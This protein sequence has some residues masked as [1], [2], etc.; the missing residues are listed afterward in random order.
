MRPDL[1]SLHSGT[2]TLDH[3]VC[4]GQAGLRHWSDMLADVERARACIRAQA[5]RLWALYEPDTYRFAVL[6]LALLAEDR[7]VLLPG[8][9]HAGVLAALNARGAQ[10]AGAFEQAALVFEEG[11]APSEFAPWCIAGS[12]AVFTSGSTGS[13]KCI[14]KSLVQVDAELGALE[15]LWGA[16]LGDSA[17]LS[18]VSHQHFYGLL[19]ALLWPLCTGRLFAQKAFV[20]P[21]HLATFSAAQRDLS[22][23]A[24][25][26]S[27]A[28][29]HRLSATMPWDARTK[30]TAV[31]SSGG[32]LRFAAAS[33]VAQALG[34]WPLEVFGSSETGGIAW[35]EQTCADAPWQPFA[36]V[37]VALTESGELT[38]A[39][40]YLPDDE[41]FITADSAT[42]QEDGRFLLGGRL[43][44][45][46]KLEGKRVAL[47]E[48]EQVLRNMDGIDDATTLALPGKRDQ[49][50][51]VLQLS[52]DGWH[53]YRE[54]GHHG[55]CQ[56]LRRELAKR[57]PAVAVPRRWRAV[58]ALP[59]NAQGK[60]VT[61]KV[62]ALFV[63]KSY[64]T[65]LGRRR[66]GE[67]LFL[68]FAALTGENPYF[69]GHFPGQSVLPGVT[70]LAWAQHFAAQ[71]LGIKH[72]YRHMRSVKFR[73][74]VFPE[75]ALE[76][77]LRYE[78]SRET[79]FF[80]YR[81]CD[82]QHSEGRLVG[83]GSE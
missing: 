4:I 41:R 39:S 80:S 71:E 51:A 17:M 6:L 3:P 78:P 9:N 19:F 25:V 36:P 69:E 64:P 28:H 60:L 18:T 27:P 58:T 35:R 63:K 70:Q 40:T 68:E 44:R 30:V 22:Q 66:E 52:R 65:V 49:L 20:D 26:M 61:A 8:D 50:G 48:V 13:P 75:T 24:W 2:F 29:L 42:L 46:V 31:F 21:V 82:G 67:S 38:V 15:D 43:D 53:A 55:F 5:D 79:L 34:Q 11:N 57:L 47:E 83:E 33:A 7:H 54:Q 59:R 62:Q 56:K 16:R 14:D 1:A 37:Q 77:E 45:I 12:L 73:S 74:L 72:L 76:L 32:P 10:L 23:V 81:S